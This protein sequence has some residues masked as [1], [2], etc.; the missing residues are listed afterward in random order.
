MK[1][2][3][4]YVGIT[5]QLSLTD[6]FSGYFSSEMLSFINPLK[7]QKKQRQQQKQ[8]LGATEILLKYSCSRT[9]FKVGFRC[10]QLV[11]NRCNGNENALVIVV[12]SWLIYGHL[13]IS[14]HG[15]YCNQQNYKKVYFQKHKTIRSHKTITKLVANLKKQQTTVF[16]DLKIFLTKILLK[17]MKK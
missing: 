15:S 6:N 3:T 17:F 13:A 1:D 12:Y 11:C 2:D 9:K 7:L 5:L 8:N 10:V 14:I 4:M 16:H